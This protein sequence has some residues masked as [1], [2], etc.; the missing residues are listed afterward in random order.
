MTDYAW[1]KG[2][3]RSPDKTFTAR[4]MAGPRAAYDVAQGQVTDTDTE[5]ANAVVEFTSVRSYLPFRLNQN[6]EVVRHAVEAVET[7]GLKPTLVFSNGGL[8]ANRLCK[9]GVPTVTIGADQYD[10]RTIREHLHLPRVRPR[11]PVGD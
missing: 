7:F 3:A 5:G 8:D 6:T 11:I 2:E 1:L 9:H 4:I 10:I